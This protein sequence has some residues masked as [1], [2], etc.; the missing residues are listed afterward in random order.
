MP[1]TKKAPFLSPQVTPT[2]S[3]RIVGFRHSVPTP[4]RDAR[5]AIAGF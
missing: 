4:L 5:D 2:M 1:P 3:P